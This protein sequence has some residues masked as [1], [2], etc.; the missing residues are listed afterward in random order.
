MNICRTPARTGSRARC[1]CLSHWK[2]GQSFPSRKQAPKQ[3]IMQMIA[4]GQLCHIMLLQPLTFDP[5]VKGLHQNHTTTSCIFKLEQGLINSST[6][7]A[8]VIQSQT[9]PNPDYIHLN[10]SPLCTSRLPAF[11]HNIRFKMH[12]TRMYRPVLGIECQADR[13]LFLTLCDQDP[14]GCDRWHKKDKDKERKGIKHQQTPKN[15]KVTHFS[16]YLYCC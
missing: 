2:S 12:D 7:A 10:M 1:V 4:F 3:T 8:W 9:W 5:D 14:P 13:S 11:T 6:T 16:I 15:H